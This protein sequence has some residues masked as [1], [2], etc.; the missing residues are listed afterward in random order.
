MFLPP[1]RWLFMGTRKETK[2]REK[3]EL[4]EEIFR[5]NKSCSSYAHHFINMD[6]N[7]SFHTRS[8]NDGG[9]KTY[10]LLF[11]IGLTQFLL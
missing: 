11:F 2:E 7:R 8:C 6:V 1:C 4:R 10:P 9:N 5:G 3:A